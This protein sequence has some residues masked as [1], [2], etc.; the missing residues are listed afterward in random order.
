MTT[1]TAKCGHARCILIQIHQCATI[2][3]LIA[4]YTGIWPLPSI[5]HLHVMS[6][7]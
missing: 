2:T 1:K 7:T 5:S 6:A 3:P 4:T